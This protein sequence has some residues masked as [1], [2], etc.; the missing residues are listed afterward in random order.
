LRTRPSECCPAGK[1]AGLV[2]VFGVCWSALGRCGDGGIL[3]IINFCDGMVA[4]MSEQRIV[5]T[6]KADQP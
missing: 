4:E 2:P 1:A 6:T 3:P 5:R